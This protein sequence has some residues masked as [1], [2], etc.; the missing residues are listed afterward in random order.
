LDGKT[1]F[2]NIDVASDAFIVKSM[3]RLLTSYEFV[4][5]L[6]NNA[7]FPFQRTIWYKSFDEVVTNDMKAIGN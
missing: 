5:I 4:D 1:H 3:T 2:A 7:D 6:E